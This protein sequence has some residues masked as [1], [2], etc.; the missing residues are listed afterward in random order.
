MKVWDADSGQE[1]LTLRGHSA[2]VTA[3]PSAPM[4]SASP[5]PAGMKLFR[6]T[7]ST[8][9]NYSTWLATASPA[10]SRPTS[11]TLLPVRDLPALALIRLFKNHRF[12]NLEWRKL[13]PQNQQP[14]DPTT[15]GVSISNE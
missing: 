6:S 2:T 12:S 5:P 8:Y 4:A 9:A 3:W 15:I 13:D 11:A 1:L 14:T 10:P 7:L